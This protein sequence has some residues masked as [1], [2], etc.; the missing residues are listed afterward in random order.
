M[1]AASSCG[2]YVSSNVNDTV[3]VGASSAMDGGSAG[4]LEPGQTTYPTQCKIPPV[5]DLSAQE[6]ALAFMLFD[7]SSCVQKD[8][9]PPIP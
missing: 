9:E 6:K 1:A 3:T 8:T 7:L 4:A 5:Q 2:P